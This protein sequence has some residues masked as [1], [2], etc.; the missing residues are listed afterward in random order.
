MNKKQKQRAKGRKS[1]TPVIFKVA[2]LIKKQ[3]RAKLLKAFDNDRQAVSN[4]I[5]AVLTDLLP[6]Q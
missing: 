4:Y 5:N 2:Q 3:E 6:E 1:G